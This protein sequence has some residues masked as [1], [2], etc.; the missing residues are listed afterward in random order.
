M[1]FTKPAAAPEKTVEVVIIGGAIR[2]CN[3]RT[4]PLS[5]EIISSLRSDGWDILYDHTTVIV[6]G[7]TPYDRKVLSRELV[8]VYQAS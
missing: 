8:K 7:F 4:S 2:I 3:F 6:A 5:Q 1:Q